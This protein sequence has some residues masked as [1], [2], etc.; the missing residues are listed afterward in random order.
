MD[1]RERIMEFFK[2]RSKA[3]GLKFDTDLFKG[4]FIN[5]LFA[6]EMVVFL[7][8]TFKIK[9]KNKDINEKNFRTVDSIAEVVERAKQK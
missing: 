4:G 1:T 8:D 5:S 2:G 7:E 3:E 6:L 9:I